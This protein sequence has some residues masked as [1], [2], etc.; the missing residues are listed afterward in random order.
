[1]NA[2]LIRPGEK[3][4]E[5]EI[6]FTPEF[7]KDYFGEVVTGTIF[8][9]YLNLQIHFLLEPTIEKPNFTLWDMTFYGN[10]LIVGGKPNGEP[11]S[12]DFDDSAFLKR[13]IKSYQKPFVKKRSRVKEL[14]ICDY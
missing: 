10:V 8:V 5:K 7:F 2:L 1:M 12:L 14:T 11:K 6:D 9:T 3:I 4:E 13:F